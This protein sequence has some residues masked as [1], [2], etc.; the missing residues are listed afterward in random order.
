MHCMSRY[1]LM[2]GVDDI[3]TSQPHFPIIFLIYIILTAIMALDLA[4]S[5]GTW[6]IVC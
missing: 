1:I 4:R 6:Q 5:R 3:V 2:E